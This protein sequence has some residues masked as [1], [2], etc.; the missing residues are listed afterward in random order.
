MNSSAATDSTKM[1]VLTVAMIKEDLKQLSSKYDA[2]KDL[3]HVFSGDTDAASSEL[4][5]V[6]T[7]TYS[8]LPYKVSCPLSVVLMFSPPLSA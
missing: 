7:G 1:P 8:Y 5:S 2:S 6:Q 4:Q 3:H